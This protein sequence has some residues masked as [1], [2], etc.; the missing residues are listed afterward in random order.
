MS[1]QGSLAGPP[2]HRPKWSLSLVFF[3]SNKTRSIPYFGGG[4]S[5]KAF[6]PSKQISE[7]FLCQSPSGSPSQPFQSVANLLGNGQGTTE[8][9]GGLWR[10][11]GQPRGIWRLA[12]RW[13]RPA[14]LTFPNRCAPSKRPRGMVPLQGPSRLPPLLEMPVATNFRGQVPARGCDPMPYAARFFRHTHFS[15]ASLRKNR[16]FEYRLRLFLMPRPAA[17]ILR[18]GGFPPTALPLHGKKMP[19][20]L[21]PRNEPRRPSRRQGTISVRK[22][23]S[24]QRP[25]RPIGGR[26]QCPECASEFFIQRQAACGAEGK[27]SMQCSGSPFPFFFSPFFAISDFKA[28]PIRARVFL[29]ILP[30]AEIPM[31]PGEKRWRLQNA[32]GAI[33]P[34]ALPPG[35]CSENRAGPDFPF[36]PLVEKERRRESP[37]HHRGPDENRLRTLRPARALVGGRARTCAESGPA[38]ARSCQPERIELLGVLPRGRRGG[39]H[40]GTAIKLRPRPNRT[41]R[42]RN[43]PIHFV[44]ICARAHC[45][46]AKSSRLPPGAR[47]ACRAGCW[48]L[49]DTGAPALTTNDIQYQ[50]PRAP[51]RILR[52]IH[53]FSI[54][55]FSGRYCK[56]PCARGAG[57]RTSA[58][59]RAWVTN[60]VISRA[61]RGNLSPVN[62]VARQKREFPPS[63]RSK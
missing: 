38:S 49:S 45:G 21:C 10:K 11:P 37:R 33:F 63:L 40:E 22:N 24:S 56:L 47:I 27:T 60:F 48:K 13:K 17:R 36:S 4:F 59:C 7:R 1:C 54:I 14:Q 41:P 53:Y 18:C 15:S 28:Q 51:I 57:A 43:A 42:T 6:P 26:R 29:P 62:L 23:V 2:G 44:Q 8:N 50:Y 30:L 35:V 31:A 55:F 16:L 19:R 25:P 5:R 20:S 12:C 46:K 9:G 39:G 52:P 58:N 3:C 32:L 61:Q 34:C